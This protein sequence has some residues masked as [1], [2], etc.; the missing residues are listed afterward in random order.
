MTLIR[1]KRIS[2]TKN[3]RT[4]TRRKAIEMS[5][6]FVASTPVLEYGSTAHALNAMEIE[7]ATGDSPP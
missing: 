5:V 1:V 3:A 7:T 4:P 2:A 6:M